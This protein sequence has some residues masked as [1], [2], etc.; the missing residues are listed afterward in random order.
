M[1]RA[2]TNIAFTPS[3]KAEQERHG[4]RKA[5]ARL[6]GEAEDVFGPAE[7]AFIGARDGFYM[8]TVNQDGWPY[9]QFRGGPRGFLEVTSP[10]SLTFVDLPGNK[11]FLTVGNLKDNDRVAL[12]LM[13]YP[14]QRRLKVWGRARVVESPKERRIVIDLV[15]FDWNC[16]QHIPRRFTPEELDLSV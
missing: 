8:A 1:A 6:E 10:R 7:I 9:V 13:D 11:Q 5:Y 15:A 14:N 3:V 16:Q 12:F 2:F 4:S